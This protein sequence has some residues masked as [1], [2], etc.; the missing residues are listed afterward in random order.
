M[1]VESLTLLKQTPVS[2]KVMYSYIYIGYN[3]YT[4]YGY[5]K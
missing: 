4:I 1:F 2:C 5:L 3:S